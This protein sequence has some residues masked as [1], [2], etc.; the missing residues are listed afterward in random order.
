METIQGC[1]LQA[2]ARQCSGDT[3][4][5]DVQGTQL[6]QCRC[7]TRVANGRVG[8]ASTGDN[9]KGPPG[10][11]GSGPHPKQTRS[12]KKLAARGS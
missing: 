9:A 3:D 10:I 6:G 1:G 4:A 5:L 7:A 8:R 2:S 11:Y 12:T